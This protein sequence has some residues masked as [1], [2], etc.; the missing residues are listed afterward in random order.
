MR[1]LIIISYRFL[2]RIRSIP[3]TL[4]IF[5]TMNHFNHQIGI[6]LSVECAKNQIQDETNITSAIKRHQFNAQKK[7]T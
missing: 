7:G 1:H 4:Y 6:Q 3:L 2:Y 5:I